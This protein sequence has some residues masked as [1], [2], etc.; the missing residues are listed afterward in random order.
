MARITMFA[1][2][3]SICFAAIVAALPGPTRTRSNLATIQ[4]RTTPPVF[5]DY[6]PSCPKCAEHYPDID[7]CAQAAPVLANFTMVLFNPTAFVDVV[8]CACADTFQA[9]FPQCVDCFVRTN[10]TDVLEAP[11]LPD[12]LEGM[13]RICAMQSVFFGNVSFANGEVTATPGPSPTPNA[14]ERVVVG[15][16]LVTT[17][18]L[19]LLA[20]CMSVVF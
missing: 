14:G 6:P 19:L 8:R 18:V 2:V 5:P 20:G 17:I 9:V 3:I 1:Y 13:R 7:S 11:S 10:Q 15:T 12:I 16:S 4:R